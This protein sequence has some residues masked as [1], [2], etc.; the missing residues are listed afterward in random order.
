MNRLETEWMR[1]FFPE[2]GASGCDGLVSPGGDVRVMV[3]E[4]G[5]PADWRLLAPLWQSVQA[6]LGWPA[7]AIAVNGRDSFALW[8]PLSAAVPAT[9]ARAVLEVLRQRYLAG[10]KPDRVLLWPRTGTEGVRHADPVPQEIVPG[11]RWSAFVA[12]DLAAVF[13]DEPALDLPPGAD[14][15]ADLLARIVAVPVQ[16]ARQLLTGA[17]SPPMTVGTGQIDGTAAAEATAPAPVTTGAHHADPRTFLLS[18]MNDSSVALA[19]RIEAAK[20][21]LGVSG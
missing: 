3:I 15:Q 17:Q 8:M 10:V 19:L 6:D 5:R 11:Q 20:A 2:P 9:E 12:P 4:L 18:V 7:P 16:A 21:L 13:G 1:L 14:A